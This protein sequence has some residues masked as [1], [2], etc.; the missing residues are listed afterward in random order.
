MRSK[1]R[2]C[3]DWIFSPAVWKQWSAAP[4]CPFNPHCWSADWKFLHL[5]L[6]PRKSFC[7]FGNISVNE[8]HSYRV[9]TKGTPLI[10]QALTVLKQMMKARS[11]FR[12]IFR[13]EIGE[14]LNPQFPSLLVLL[15]LLVNH[16]YRLTIFIH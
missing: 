8:I 11:V 5:N 1:K 7:L 4:P 10:N 13:L 12:F 3:N 14:L 6:F 2:C 9:K 15:N 16:Q